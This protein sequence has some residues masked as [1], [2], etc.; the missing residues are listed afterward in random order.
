MELIAR[1]EKCVLD[2]WVM[3]GDHS[4]PYLFGLS[5]LSRTRNTTL[6]CPI[7]TQNS[8]SEENSNSEKNSDSEIKF[9]RVAYK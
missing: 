4:S 3:L 1:S 2:V 5:N 9:G 8:N 7:R 6:P